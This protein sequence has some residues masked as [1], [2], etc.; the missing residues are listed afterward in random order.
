MSNELFGTTKEGELAS[1]RNIY[2]RKIEKYLL[3][4]VINNI[5]VIDN[6]DNDI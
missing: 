1:G 4:R 3:N 6:Y 5:S 2:Y